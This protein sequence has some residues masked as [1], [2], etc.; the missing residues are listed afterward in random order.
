M[1]T[2]KNTQ[3]NDKMM[4]FLTSDMK[5]SHMSWIWELVCKKKQNQTPNQWTW[6]FYIIEKVY[7]KVVGMTWRINK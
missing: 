3:K 4:A 5:L 7:R 6:I 2:E 1:K